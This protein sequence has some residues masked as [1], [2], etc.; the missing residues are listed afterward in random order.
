MLP[1]LGPNRPKPI[2]RNELCYRRD[3]EQEG[4]YRKAMTAEEELAP[5]LAELRRTHDVLP[6]LKQQIPASEVEFRRL[7]DEMVDLLAASSDFRPP[8]LGAAPV[9]LQLETEERS[10]AVRIVARPRS[11]GE[12]WVVAQRSTKA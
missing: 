12:L 2:S 7:P 8:A 1:S 11:D 4:R 10:H 5:I 6:F 9:W 3:F